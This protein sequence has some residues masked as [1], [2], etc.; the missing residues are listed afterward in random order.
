MGRNIIF[1]I[2]FVLVYGFAAI[3]GSRSGSGIPTDRTGNGEFAATASGG[4]RYTSD[5][6]GVEAEFSSDWIVYDGVQL[7]KLYR[8][9][10]SESE[11]EEIFECDINKLAYVGGFITPDA[12][13]RIT[14]VE[15]E[16]L[17]SEMFAP[18]YLEDIISYS[19]EAI[20]YSGGKWGAGASYIIPAKG[21]A[22]KVIIFYYD[23]ELLGEYDATY[24]AMLNVGKNTVYLN[25]YY[26][27][28][29]GLNML[30][31]FTKNGFAVTASPNVA[32]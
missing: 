26:S 16:T 2:L 20:V 6:Y 12:T 25:G 1:I 13:I 27:N 11:I 28:P 29:E 22:D 9:N 32:V 21:S 17:P 18:S 5:A 10:F 4:C 15:N 23:Y 30:L 31:N 8:E 14:I 7:E 24:T 3:L 19:R